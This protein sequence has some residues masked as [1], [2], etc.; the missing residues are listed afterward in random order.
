MTCTLWLHWWFPLNIERE[1][2]PI[3]SNF[4]KKLK[5]M[6]HLLNHSVRPVALWYQNQTKIPQKNF[7]RPIALM[8]TDT[9]ILNK[10]LANRIQQWIKRIIHQDQERFTPEM[11]RLFNMC[12]SISVIHHINRLKNKHHLKRCRKHF[13][14]NSTSIYN[15]KHS[16]KWAWS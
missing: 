4:S 6:E 12:K 10:I 1:T 8:N 11:Q 15:K 3:Y 5:M 14:S 9:K 7:Y 13:W 2:I 16:R